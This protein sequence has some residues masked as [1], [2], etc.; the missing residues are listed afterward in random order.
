M[1]LGMPTRVQLT[2]SHKLSRTALEVR[3]PTLAR[4]TVERFEVAIPSRANL[5][6]APPSSSWTGFQPD[7]YVDYGRFLTAEGGILFIHKDLD[8]R[9]RH[10]LW[11]LF[12]W[13]LST[14][15]E[16]WFL[17]HHPPLHTEWITFVCFLAVA[18]AHGRCALASASV[19]RDTAPVPR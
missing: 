16:G 7:P 6:T 14:G 3:R 1:M 5:A 15:M 8:L 17:F 13:T 18:F 10:T 4:R 19:E 2:R 12:A 9:L 11:R